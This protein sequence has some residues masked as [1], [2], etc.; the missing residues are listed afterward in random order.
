MNAA[1]PTAGAGRRVLSSRTAAALL[2]LTL[3]LALGLW[4]IRRGGSLWRDEVVTYD[5]AHRTLPELW[6]TLQNNDMVH[7]LYYFLMHG[8]F[9]VFGGDVTTLRLP[10]VLAMA[11]A[12]AGIGLL[13]YR[14]AGPRAGLLAGLVFPMVPA[15]QQYAQEGRSYAVVCAMVTWATYLLVR[16]A[17]ES[18]RRRWVAYT[19]VALLACLLHEF[20]VLMLTAHGATV[21]LAADVPRTVR[22]SWA[23]SASCVVAGLAPLAVF[24]M[25]QS[26][27]VRWI[28]WPDPIQLV[29]FVILAAIGLRC[30]RIPMRSKGPIPLRTLA[31]PLLILPTAVLLLVSNLKPMYVDRYVLY[32]VI[33]FALLAG[34]ALD[35]AFRKVAEIQRRKWVWLFSAM[36]VLGTLLPVAVHLR[37]PDSRVDDATA[38]T[39]AVREAARPGDGLVFTPARRR[40]WTL[41]DPEQFRAYPDLA[42]AQKV[43]ASQSLYGE[44]IS[45]DR[46]RARM[47]AADRLV[48][49]GDP[50]GKPLDETAQE[51]AKRTTL[52]DHF[53]QCSAKEVTGARVTVYARPGRC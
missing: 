49:L 17:S 39:E 24:S 10:S 37:S 42:L 38:V 22:K 13:G 53:E 30:A 25:G 35:R 32:Y 36:A 26:D 51:R 52:E 5:M 23:I 1:A 15:V 14:F 7:G 33:G 47:L 31:V 2:P 27:Q 16:A 50:D 48:V 46:I 11:A 29:S 6:E 41:A 19:L 20:A 8:L 43:D 4:G 18:S 21:V 44:E 28:M 34:A 40:V 9:A 12:A 45:P 3:T